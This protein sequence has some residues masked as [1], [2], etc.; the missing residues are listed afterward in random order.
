MASAKGVI[1]G[2]IARKTHINVSY[3]T[4]EANVVEGQFSHVLPF[5]QLQVTGVPN[6]P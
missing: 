2:R 4:H 1:S 5:P 3:E 6:N